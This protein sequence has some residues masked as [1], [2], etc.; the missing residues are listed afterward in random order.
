MKKISTVILMLFTVLFVMPIVKAQ[1]NVNTYNYNYEDEE[2]VD[3]CCDYIHKKGLTIGVTG[4]AVLTG[5]VTQPSWGQANHSHRLMIRPNFGVDLGLQFARNYSVSIGLA[6]FNLGASLDN[7]A[8]YLKSL[9]K[10]VQE[11]RTIKSTYFSIPVMV[12]YVDNRSRFNFVG[13]LGFSYA[14]LLSAEQE[15]TVKDVNTG[16]QWPYSYYVDIDGEMVEVNE[17]DVKDRFHSSEIMINAE[18]GVRLKATKRL[19]IDLVTTYNWSLLSS[20]KKVWNDLPDWQPKDYLSHVPRNVFGGFK[21]N[22]TYKLGRYK[23][24]KSREEDL[25]V[26]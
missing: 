13:G 4:S 3:T 8:Y 18:A 12:R 26:K 14:M 20:T 19:N 7:H 5:I 11:D 2:T 1:N 15:W 25:K 22:L 24:D 6:M 10:T 17:K 9:G 16:D 21:L 23:K